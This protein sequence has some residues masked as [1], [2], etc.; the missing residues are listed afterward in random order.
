MATRSGVKPMTLQ[1]YVHHSNCYTSYRA[2]IA[3]A[4]V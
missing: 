2:T 4:R 3:Q 1:S